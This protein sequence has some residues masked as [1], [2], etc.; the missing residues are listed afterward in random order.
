[1]LDLLNDD[2]GLVRTQA[3]ND[4]ELVKFDYDADADQY[5]YSGVNTDRNNWDT[6]NIQAS[7][8]QVKLGIRYNF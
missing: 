7:T 5:V 4:K 6:Y 3:Y 1:M 2:W 8:W